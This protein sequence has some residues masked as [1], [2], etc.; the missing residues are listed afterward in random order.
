MR[1]VSKRH[2]ESLTEPVF[3]ILVSLAEEPRHGYA[4]LKDVEALSNQRIRMSTGTL[5]GALRRMLED[6][7]IAHSREVDA[8]RGRQAYRLT[9]PGRTV[10]NGEV[11]RMKLLARLASSRLAR[12][13]A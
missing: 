11:D 12:G 5:Y 2:L 9:T 1:H 3:L 6:G 13:E 7:W 4:I 8:P 10:L